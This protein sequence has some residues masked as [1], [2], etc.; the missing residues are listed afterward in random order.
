VALAAWDV[1]AQRGFSLTAVPNTQR[2]I[3]TQP[4]DVRN[5]PATC[6]EKR[7]YVDV[8]RILQLAPVF[9][10]IRD[11]LI[12]SSEQVAELLV[13][14]IEQQD[15]NKTMTMMMTAASSPPRYFAVRKHAR[16][17]GAL[18]RLQT[19]FLPRQARDKH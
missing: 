7:I 17:F 2:G 15:N 11:I 12:R 13:R 5:I 9:G 6:S 4:Y 18:F 8:T 1:A 10:P 16:C 3:A 19:I 14:V